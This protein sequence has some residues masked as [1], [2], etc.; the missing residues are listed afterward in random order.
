MKY[1]FLRLLLL[2]ALLQTAQLHHSNCFAQDD[3]L[4]YELQIKMVLMEDMDSEARAFKAAHPDIE[5]KIVFN[6][7]N[8]VLKIS[9]CETLD[10][11]KRLQKL[12]LEEYP[13]SVIIPCGAGPEK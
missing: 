6:A 12:L 13:N 5:L 8:F 7:P 1:R 3:S 4:Y 11:M 2:F 10:F 9:G